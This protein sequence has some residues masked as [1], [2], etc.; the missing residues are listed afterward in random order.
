MK[1]IPLTQGKFALVDDKDYAALSKHKWYARR[2]GVLF[3]AGR[4]IK[5]NGKRFNVH[6]HREIMKTPK[7]FD[8]DHLNGN[9]LDNRRKN[10]RVC[11]HADNMKNRPR[12]NRNN[13]SGHAGVVWDKR[14]KK[15][16]AQMKRNYKRIRIGSFSR[17]ADAIKAR[18][19]ALN[20]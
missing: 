9:G 16:I 12:L 6:M 11:S 1:I 3:Y 10:L 7:G 19:K 4:G 18:V 14:D 2:I 5:R 13:T 8:T 17:K 20:P 15:W